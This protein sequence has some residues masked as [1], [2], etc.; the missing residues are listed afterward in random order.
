MNRSVEDFRPPEIPARDERFQML[1]QFAYGGGYHREPLPERLAP[2]L[3]RVGHVGEPDAFRGILLPDQPIPE[4]LRESPELARAL[5]RK[6][7]RFFPRVFRMSIKEFVGFHNH[8]G[9]DAAR[10]KGVDRRAQNGRAAARIANGPPVL[11]F[12][13]AREWRAFKIH[14]AGLPVAYRRGGD[15]AVF[16]LEEGLHELHGS[17]C[18][19]GMPHVRL[20]GPY[21]RPSFPLR[22]AVDAVDAFP[23]DPVHHFGAHGLQLHASDARGIDPGFGKRPPHEGFLR[24]WRRR[25]V[26]VAPAPVGKGARLDD[27]V[28]VVAVPLGGREGLE[29]EKRGPFARNEPVAPPLEE[30]APPLCGEHPFLA[31]PQVFGW[32]QVE[33][34]A[35]GERRFAAAA[36]QGFARGLYGGHGG[37]AGDVY[38]EARAVEIEEVR[39]AVRDVVI[40]RVRRNAVAPRGGEHRIRVAGHPDVNP[41]PLAR[42]VGAAPSGVV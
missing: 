3:E 30:A 16:Y 5:S 15:F 37:R 24:P 19:L 20:E 2:H 25:E 36:A 21:P 38:G 1:F 14:P 17:R 40:C 41:D 31:H 35:S 42:Q 27:A 9:F 28:D 6:D 4:V 18:G 39:D 7:E 8:M 11:G 29:K 33:V 10:A 26:A 12:L 23:L 22:F 13:G 32:M 34:H